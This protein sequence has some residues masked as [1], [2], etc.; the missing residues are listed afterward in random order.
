MRIKERRKRGKGELK[1]DKTKGQKERGKGE[2]KI[3]K[4]SGKRKKEKKINKDTEREK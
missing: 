4:E 3:E 2:C 1:K